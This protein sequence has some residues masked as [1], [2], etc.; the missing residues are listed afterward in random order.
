MI[1]MLH[2]VGAELFF[3]DDADNGLRQMACE[4]PDL[5]LCHVD[6]PDADAE[7]LCSAIR[8]S[9][10]FS[11]VPFI[12]VGESGREFD[13]VIRALQAGVDDFVSHDFNGYA[14]V[15]KLV[16]LMHQ[17]SG[18][19]ARSREYEALRRDQLR[20]LD[21]VRETTAIFRAFDGE[22]CGTDG[23]DERI[24]VGLSMI[25]GLANILED[26]MNAV[27]CWFGRVDPHVAGEFDTECTSGLF[28]VTGEESF[29][30]SL[31]V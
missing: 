1:G 28:L 18:E 11:Q 19:A 4:R 25:A 3:A 23:L 13:R 17:R 7:E 31:A 22:A 10:S 5:V 9:K 24:E 2:M 27:D 15:A 26:Q 20:T 8:G 29:E 6:L 12:I 30:L 21:I 14:F 16:W